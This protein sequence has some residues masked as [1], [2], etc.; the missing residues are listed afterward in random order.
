MIIEAIE[1]PPSLLPSTVTD[2]NPS[3]SPPLLLSL[4]FFMLIIII[5]IF[6][7][8]PRSKQNPQL[9]LSTITISMTKSQSLLI[10]QE[11]HKLTHHTNAKG[12]PPPFP[13]SQ[14]LNSKHACL[15]SYLRPTLLPACSAVHCIPRF[16]ARC[17][18]V[19]VY[20]CMCVW[21]AR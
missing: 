12:I 14:N 4:L 11:T 9:Y 8:P 17:V 6:V 3:F 7:P 15:T 1:P 10:D 5:I 18:C 16:S 21:R 13:N 19:C 2:S 20:V